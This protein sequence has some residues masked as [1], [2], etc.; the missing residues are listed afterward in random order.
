MW[1]GLLQSWKGSKAEKEKT[2]AK[3]HL[4][5]SFEPSLQPSTYFTI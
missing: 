5:F 4:I 2:E 1:A 3:H